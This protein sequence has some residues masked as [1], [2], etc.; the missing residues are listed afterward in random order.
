M[1]EFLIVMPIEWVCDNCN[2]TN[3]MIDPIQF[4]R[5]EN[6]GNPHETEMKTIIMED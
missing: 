4:V 2:F 1:M 3:H 6:C 5:C